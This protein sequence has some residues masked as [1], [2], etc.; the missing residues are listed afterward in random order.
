MIPTTFGIAIVVIP[1]SGHRDIGKAERHIQILEIAYRPM[2]E[3]VGA[4]LDRSLKFAMALMAR[5]ST[6][7][8]P[9]S[10]PPLTALTGRPS[11][12]E[13]LRRAAFEP[14]PSGRCDSE[15]RH[16]RRRTQSLN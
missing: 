16:F 12:V 9:T 13:D 3:S 11:I 15:E 6:P 5:N 4:A 8:S 14:T 1:V 2:G 7:S 10:I